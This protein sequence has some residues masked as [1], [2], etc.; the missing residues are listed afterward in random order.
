MRQFAGHYP[1]YTAEAVLVMPY[2]RFLALFA[3]ALAELPGGPVEMARAEEQVA[4]MRRLRAARRQKEQDH[5]AD[6]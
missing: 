4:E 1:A 2:Y 6:S 5:N 3:A